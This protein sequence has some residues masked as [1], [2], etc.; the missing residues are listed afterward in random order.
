MNAFSQGDILGRNE[1]NEF[2]EK[3][4]IEPRNSFYAPC[5]NMDIIRRQLN[6]LANSYQKLGDTE[7]SQ[8]LGTLRHLLGPVVD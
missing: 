3:L 8:E 7:R 6:N 1:I 4:K 2:L 5:T